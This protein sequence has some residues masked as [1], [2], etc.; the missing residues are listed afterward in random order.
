MDCISIRNWNNL[1]FKPQTNIFPGLVLQEGKIELDFHKVEK[2]N[3]R[4]WS[5]GL[6]V[7]PH[8]DK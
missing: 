3:L 8:M 2:K 1:I 4:I 7:W 6:I 5:G